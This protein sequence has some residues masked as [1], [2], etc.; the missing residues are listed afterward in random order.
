MNKYKQLNY[1]ERV[2]I[3]YGL[4]KG[5]GIREISHM[6]ERNSGTISGKIKRGITAVHILLSL[7]IEC[8][9]KENSTINESEK[10]IILYAYVSCRLKKK[11]FLIS[12]AIA[13]ALIRSFFEFSIC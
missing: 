13:D 10:R 6:L 8:Y 1:E 3:R 11:S 7:Q 9:V 4:F 12:S 2:A 5:A